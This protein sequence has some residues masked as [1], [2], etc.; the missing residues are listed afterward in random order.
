[1]TGNLHALPRPHGNLPGHTTLIL[2]LLRI[3]AGQNRP[4][5]GAQNTL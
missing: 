3:P 2:R 5:P 1:M 4:V